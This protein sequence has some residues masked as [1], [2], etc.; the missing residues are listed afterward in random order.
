MNPAI[1]VVT[2]ATDATVQRAQMGKQDAM[3]AKVN[4]VQR[5]RPAKM[6]DPADP[7][8]L[9]RPALMEIRA[10]VDVKARVVNVAQQARLA[11]QV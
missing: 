9:V 5:E 2:D 6:E 4:V 8:Q 1:R 7:A 10:R 3:A 11:Q